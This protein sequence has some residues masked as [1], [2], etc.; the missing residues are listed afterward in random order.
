M[1]T[2][3]L[4]R[5]DLGLAPQQ[6]ELLNPTGW[7]S[8]QSKTPRAERQRRGGFL[9]VKRQP[10]IQKLKEKGTDKQK[11]RGIYSTAGGRLGFQC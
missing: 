9:A 10:L 1:L 4:S 11:D 7:C 6:N 8:E 3:I 5:A 2:A